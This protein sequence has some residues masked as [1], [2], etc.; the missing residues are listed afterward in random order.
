MKESIFNPGKHQDDIKS[1][2]IVGLERISESFRVLLRR[3]AKLSGLSPLQIQVLIFCAYHE[4]NLCKVSHLA[5]EFNVTKATV[6]DAVKSLHEKKLINKEFDKNDSRIYTI[7]PS[8]DGKAALKKLE[9]FAAPVKD[10]LDGLPGKSL[11]DFYDSTTKIIYG[12]NKAGILS[13]Q[14]TCYN[15]VYYS[16]SGE[17][18]YCRLL[19]SE[20]F[21]KDIRLDCPEFELQD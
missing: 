1:K 5:E 10:I 6:S 9:S 12:L 2:I 21:T 11:E 17:N 7:S 8:D 19:Q 20:L 16:A 14:R 4:K 15:C 18:H 13:V 3:Q